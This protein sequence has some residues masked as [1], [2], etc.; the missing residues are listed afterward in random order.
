MDFWLLCLTGDILHCIALW[1]GWIFRAFVFVLCKSILYTTG[2]LFIATLT[3]QDLKGGAVGASGVLMLAINFIISEDLLALRSR[4]AMD[5][6]YFC[7][8]S[9]GMVSST[10]KPLWDSD[11]WYPLET[12]FLVQTV[13]LKMSLSK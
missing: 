1:R 9:V 5:P 4:Y 10:F 6:W 13:L 7:H 8:V 2:F 12:W 3:Y 11:S